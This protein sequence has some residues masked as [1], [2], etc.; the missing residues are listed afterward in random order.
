MDR[1]QFTLGAGAALAGITLANPTILRAQAAWPTQP[2]RLMTASAASGNA[3]IVT[4]IIAAELEQRLG[5]RIILEAMPQNSGMQAT[6]TVSNATPDGYTLLV[7]TSS[8]LVFNLA[9]FDPMPVDL[10]QTLRGVA[11]MNAVPLILCVKADHP[12]QTMVEYIEWLKANPDAQYG[13]GP[14]GTTTHVTG[15]LWARAAG[16]EVEHVPYNAGSEA[17]QDVIAGRLSHVFDVAVTAIPQLQAGTV[18]GLAITS[19]ER[20]AAAPDI[21]TVAEQGLDGFLAQTW[22]SIAA[23]AGLPQEIVDKL[24]AEVT[25]VLGTPEVRE[26]LEALA[27][28]FFPAM[29]PTE[30]DAFYASER[31][32]WIRSSARLSAG[33]EARGTPTHCRRRVRATRLI[34]ASASRGLFLSSASPCLVRRQRIECRI[35]VGLP[36]DL[37]PGLCARLPTGLARCAGLF[38]SLP[39]AFSRIDICAIIIS[40]QP[41]VEARRR[42]C[43]PDAARLRRC[44]SHL[45]GAVPPSLARRSREFH[46]SPSASGGSRAIRRRLRAASACYEDRRRDRPSGGRLSLHGADAA[47]AGH[48]GNALHR[49]LG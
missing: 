19:A 47:G 8:Q 4:Q 39:G 38:A 41:N 36:T 48:G 11:L 26:R 20:S 34:K 28:S 16:V 40:K 35:Q 2:I 32:T 14:L 13:S 30:V 49:G 21:P 31:E 22:N 15:M 5:Q 3:Y 29:S 1:R 7:G 37:L 23:P 12:A 18:R 46:S 33:D 43:A 17:M 6:E 42:R 9:T 10:T 25:A 45:D 24:N 27:S 44:A